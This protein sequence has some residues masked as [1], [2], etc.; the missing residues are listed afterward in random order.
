M[1]DRLNTLIHNYPRQCT[2]E[3]ANV[4]NCDQSIIVRHYQSMCKV[5]ISGVR[6]PHALNQGC[7]KVAHCVPAR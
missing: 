6:V 3:L 4:I 7:A 1:E 5:Q 2:R